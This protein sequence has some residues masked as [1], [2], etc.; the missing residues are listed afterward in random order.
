MKSLTSARGFTARESAVF[1]RLFES[2]AVPQ[3]FLTHIQ[4][5]ANLT[6]PV[7]APAGDW[8]K[9]WPPLP[10]QVGQRGRAG[11]IHQTR[12]SSRRAS[13]AWLRRFREKLSMASQS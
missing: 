13:R 12:P 4:A 2:D 6:W 10:W 3:H 8:G 7:Y 1:E 11:T 5:I 9:G